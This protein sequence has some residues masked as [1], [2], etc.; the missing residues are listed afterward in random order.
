MEII[1]FNCNENRKSYSSRS[2]PKDII[3][4][5]NKNLFPDEILYLYY[6]S[7]TQGDIINRKTTL[8]AGQE[9]KFTNAS[10][11]LFA[12]DIKFPELFYKVIL[13]LYLY[14]CFSLQIINA[15]FKNEIR[16]I[17]YQDMSLVR[18]N[19]DETK[20]NLCSNWSNSKSE[21]ISDNRFYIEDEDIKGGF[22]VY[23]KESPGLAN[24]PKP[25]WFSGWLSVESEVALMENSANFIKNSFFPSGILKLPGKLSPEEISEVK[26]KIKTDMVGPENVGKMMVI[27]ADADKAV[28]WIP[29][30][31]NMDSGGIQGYLDMVRQ[32]II[33][34][35]SLTSPS[36]IGLPTI[37]G[38][39]D[40][41]GQL[42]TAYKLYF[43]N[44]LLPVQNKVKSIFEDLFAK[45]GFETEIIIENDLEE[46]IAKLEEKFKKNLQ[47]NK[48]L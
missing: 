31:Q 13:D 45:A 7:P 35:N 10:A 29:L 12:K 39:G 32:N 41:G 2:I 30:Q 40:N 38:L 4:W 17:I 33:I 22:Y 44:E 27:S 3:K 11:E 37:A 43:R 23:I 47:T 25:S 34:A 24:Y 14:N 6:N 19:T 15:S 36:I 5:G 18:L 46:T 20:V 21:I 8:T 26:N 48:I 16:D 1:Q 28:E 42:D 9:I